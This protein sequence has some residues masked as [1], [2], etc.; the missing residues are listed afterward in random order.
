MFGRFA[1]DVV[2]MA[3]APRYDAPGARLVADALA[4]SRGAHDRQRELVIASL[5]VRPADERDTNRRAA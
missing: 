3:V 1:A 2:L 4:P 5:I